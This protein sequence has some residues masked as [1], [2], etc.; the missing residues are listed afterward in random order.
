[1]TEQHAKPEVEITEEDQADQFD[2][3]SEENDDLL[4]ASTNVT[5]LHEGSPFL[6]VVRW[7]LAG[8]SKLIQDSCHNYFVIVT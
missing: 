4:K 7:D 3:A 1:M 5:S 2:F 8:Q 6:S